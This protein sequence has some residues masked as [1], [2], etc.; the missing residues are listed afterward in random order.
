MTLDKGYSD[1]HIQDE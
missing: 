1:I